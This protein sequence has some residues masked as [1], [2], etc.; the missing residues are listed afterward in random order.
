MLAVENPLL[1]GSIK[2][3]DS[4]VSRNKSKACNDLYIS[5]SNVNSF[6][7][8][9]GDKKWS[10]ITEP[11]LPKTELEICGKAYFKLKEIILTCCLKQPQKSLH[12][13]EAPGGFVQATVEAYPHI[14]TWYACSLT[15]ESN[16]QFRKNL[17]DMSKGEIL[18][19]EQNG[20]L[21][22]PNV[23]E[24]FSLKVD[25]V[26][27]DGACM[28]DEHSSWELTN[29]SI[30]AAQCDT[31]MRCLNLGGNF[32]CKFFEGME[33]K[34]Q[35]LICVLT[36]CFE[37]VSVIKPKSSKTTNSERYIVCRGFEKYIDVINNIW[38]CSEMWLDDLQEVLDEYCVHQRNS[39]ENIFTKYK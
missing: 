4:Y 11:V 10:K 33:T 6:K 16:I 12:I 31:A 14:Q 35:V 28:N 7:N 29:Y 19:L 27:A 36:N 13:C 1:R 17:L 24:S 8:K 26:T 39:L 21:L 30:L 9:V 37:Y 5:K 23:R 3:S 38:E 18:D 2:L 20:N 32:V 15:G 22:E 25:F 34:T